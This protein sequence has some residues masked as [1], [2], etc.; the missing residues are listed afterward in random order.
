MLRLTTIAGLMLILLISSAQAQRDQRGIRDQR[1]FRDRD[2]FEQR[3]PNEFRDQGDFRERGRNPSRRANLEFL[4]E[5]RVKL[6]GETDTITINRPREWFERR[7]FRAL[8]FFVDE[9]DIE[10]G[11]VTIKYINGY[12]EPPREIRQFIRRGNRFV[13]PIEPPISFIKEITM[14]Y[15]SNPQN[16]REAVV[17]VWG[18]I[19]RI[20]PPGRD[21]WVK[22]D[23]EPV[24]ILDATFHS[25]KVG[26]REGRF[27]AIRLHA[28][29][30]DI[31]IWNL[32]VYY[33][34]TTTEDIYVFP[35]IRADQFTTEL[36]LRGNQ[37]SIDRIEFYTRSNVL[38]VDIVLGERFYRPHVCVQGFQ[39]VTSEQPR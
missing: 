18:E 23:C 4:G 16:P 24:D 37:R 27:M 25:I 6:V 29:L 35:H 10:L 3:I 15:V 33:S 34:N 8:H 5:R 7:L 9:N 21:E 36:D 1:E 13:M 22:I 31:Q 20:T 17:S 39:Y 2:R 28:L 30:A 38:P 11:S 19:D 32:K 14:L 12:A 26:R